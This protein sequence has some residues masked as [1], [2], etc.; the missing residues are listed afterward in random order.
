LL[1]LCTEG[2]GD[3]EAVSKAAAHDGRCGSLNALRI[4]EYLEGLDF[5]GTEESEEGL[6]EFMRYAY[7][8]GVLPDVPDLQ[9]FS[10]RPEA[11][12]EHP[13]APPSAS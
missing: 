2:C 9:Y 8:H 13:A 7:Y 4:R 3:F 10:S 6:R 1:A 12:G 11:E 5:E